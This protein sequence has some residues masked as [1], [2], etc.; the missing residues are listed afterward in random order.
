MNLNAYTGVR[1]LFPMQATINDSPCCL[2]GSAT[3]I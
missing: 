1:L 3:D 2:L